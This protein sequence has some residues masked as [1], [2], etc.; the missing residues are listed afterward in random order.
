VHKLK[1]YDMIVMQDE[2]IS[3]WRKKQVYENGKDANKEMRKIVQ[4]SCM[5]L[6]KAKLMSLP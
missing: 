2:Q 4:H 6:V 5:G 1:A 3:E